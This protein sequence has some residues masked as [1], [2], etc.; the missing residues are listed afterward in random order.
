MDVVNEVMATLKGAVD[1]PSSSQFAKAE[2]FGSVLSFCELHPKFILNLVSTPEFT[3]YFRQVLEKQ[4]SSNVAYETGLSAIEALCRGPEL[5]DIRGVLL[6][7]D[8]FTS[9]FRRLSS[10]TYSLPMPKIERVR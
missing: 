1:S 3:Q 6:D 10:F 9:F 7:G 5:S 8:V 4:A 2:A